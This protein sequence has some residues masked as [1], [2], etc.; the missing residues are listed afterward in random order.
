MSQ[1]AFSTL[2]WSAF[3]NWA[4]DSQDLR[5]EFHAATG[6]APNRADRVAAEHFVEWATREH[7][8]LEYAP[9]AYQQALL[10]K[11]TT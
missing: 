8:G 1:D 5:E 11:A 6:V 9:R 3:V 7:Y 10:E 4:W 2:A